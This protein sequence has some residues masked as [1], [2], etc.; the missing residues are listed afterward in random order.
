V[1]RVDSR[2][3]ALTPTKAA[4]QLPRSVGDARVEE[5]PRGVIERAFREHGPFLNGTARRLCGNASD[6]QDLVQ[7]ALER[8]LAAV[9]AGEVPRNVRGWLTSI[10]Y[11]L[12]IDR[13]RGRQRGPRFESIEPG[14]QIA[15]PAALTDPAWID[16]TPEQLHAAVDQL[17]EEFRVVYQMHAVQGRSYIEIAEALGIPKVTVGTRL[18]RARQRLREKLL[19]LTGAG[20]EQP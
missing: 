5:R 12:Y 4:C 17:D 1:A 20:S 18:V 9:A 2:V 16:I 3:G 13:Y 7:D 14:D 10:V 19:P 6:A 15:S 11:N 8:A